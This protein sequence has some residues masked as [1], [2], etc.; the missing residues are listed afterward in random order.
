MVHAEL[1][2]SSFLLSVWEYLKLYR[3][4]FCQ[5]SEYFVAANGSFWLFRCGFLLVVV[6]GGFGCTTSSWGLCGLMFFW[7][8]FWVGGWLRKL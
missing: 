2:S 7:F 3:S 6:V 4:L 1:V 8:G 5:I